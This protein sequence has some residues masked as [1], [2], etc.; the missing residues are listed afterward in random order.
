[1]KRFLLYLKTTN[2]FPEL[3]KIAGIKNENSEKYFVLD[4]N[5]SKQ[6]K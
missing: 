1:M 4:L 3:L 6:G 5:Y 2:S